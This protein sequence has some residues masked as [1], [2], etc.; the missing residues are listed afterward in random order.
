MS[1]HLQEHEEYI[2]HQT[3]V[4]RIYNLHEE[5]LDPLYEVRSHAYPKSLQEFYIICLFFFNYGIDVYI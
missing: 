4:R 3:G 1:V 5:I 2:C